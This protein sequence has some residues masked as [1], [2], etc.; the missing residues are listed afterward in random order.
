[1]KIKVLIV[2][3][4]VLVADDIAGSLER[5]GYEVVG[6]AISAEECLAAIAVNAPHVILMDIHI[7]GALD[8]IETA[9]K[10]GHIP[11]IFITSNTGSKFVSRALEV[12]PHAFISKPYNYTDVAAAIDL[13]F[14]R[15]NEQVFR[16]EQTHETPDAIFVRKGDAY[17]KVLLDQVLF[18]EA[19]GSYC[20][21]TTTDEKLTLSFNLNHFQSNLQN[22]AFK[23]IH[24][25]YVVNLKKVDRFD[26]SG[27]WIAGTYLPV[28]STYRQEVFSYFNRI[29]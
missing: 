22:P 2:E 3:D 10:V 21:V 9:K 24:R 20:E 7:K 29:Y 15:S 23:R 14:T 19:S 27:V 11:V 13:A 25:S 1:M 18:I 4:E 6:I 28:S 16:N 8:G 17:T 26:A 12:F 5:D